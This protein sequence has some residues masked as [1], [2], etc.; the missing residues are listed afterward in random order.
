MPTITGRGSTRHR[1]H[2]LPSCD[3]KMAVSCHP[4]PPYH[5][6]RPRPAR[7]H[8][9][10]PHNAWFFPHESVGIRFS[11][12][13]P[14]VPRPSA[15]ARFTTSRSALLGHVAL[16]ST[17]S[18]DHFCPLALASGECAV[19]WCAAGMHKSSLATQPRATS[20]LLL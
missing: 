20:H 7:R 6:R 15:S 2:H 19:F 13:L 8:M 3:F 1:G 11:F 9:S 17:G 18:R 14:R 5:C 12:P 4:L 16:T 10:T